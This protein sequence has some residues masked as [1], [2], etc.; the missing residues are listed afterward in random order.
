MALTRLD[1]GL[2]V[3][4]N[5]AFFSILGLREEEALGRPTGNLGLWADLG[6]RTALI[7]DVRRRGHAAPR[8]VIIRTPDG[9]RA[10]SMSASVLDVDGTRFLFTVAGDVTEE[11]A[12]E[13]ERERLAGELKESAARHR[14]AVR[15]VP[16]VQWAIDE[17]GRFTLS[18]GL[19]LAGLGLKPGQV[20]GL[21]VEEVYRDYPGVLQD[22]RRALA[23]ESFVAI[24]DFGAVVFESHWAPLRDD[25]GAVVGV[26]GVA[27]D[28]TA[29]RRAEAERRQAEGH[30][31]LLERL[32][33]VGRLAAGVAHEINNPLTYVLTSLDAAA[34]R[35]AGPG[36]DPG[37]RELVEEAR[38]GAARVR[39]IVGDLRTFGRV[40]EDASGACPVG[41]AAEAAL[42]MVRNEIR[43]RARLEVEIDRGPRAAIAEGRLAQVLVNLLANACQAIPV[44]R[45]AENLIRVAVRA[46]GERVEI[47]VSDT[48]AGMTAEVKARIFEPFFTTRGGGEGMGLGL[49]LSHAMVAEAGG[50]VDVESEPG[51]GTTFRIRLP[52][53]PEATAPMPAPRRAASTSVRALR[54]L[55][56]DDEPQVGRAVA[57][58]LDGHAVEVV[59][60]ATQALERIRAGPGFDVL[61]CDLM[62]PDLTGMDLRERLLAEAPGLAARMVFLTGGA[63]TDRTRDFLASG[64]APVLEKPVDPAALRAL[65]AEVGAGRPVAVGALPAGPA[66][67]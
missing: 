29:R 45:A 24:N 65:V 25:A 11:R 63:F 61:I 26:T 48:G 66:P 37:L 47:D 4:A 41:A 58:L 53:A 43:H 12:A 23:G 9:P 54:V 1:D 52:L 6:Q 34:E 17:A 49:A 64:V 14:F 38:G 3:A 19:G 30:L 36:A 21:R 42:A 44:G 39:A 32:A 46:R 55:V 59:T 2:L 33:A 40:R 56:V 8:D 5:H 22:Y 18:E 20:V 10:V 57:R 16:V 31:A 27:L 60:G 15:S 62:M 35:L 28:V 13:A 50:T 67:R 51:R 7:E